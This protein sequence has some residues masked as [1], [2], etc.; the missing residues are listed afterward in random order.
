VTERHG[1]GVLHVI[2][3]VSLQNRFTHVELAR[4][5][6]RGGADTVQFREKRRLPATTLG[7]IAR[8]MLRRVRQHAVRLLINDRVDLAAA[9]GADGVHLGRYDLP[10]AEARRLLG[11]GALIGGTANSLEQAL[12]V[13]RCAVD[14]I[15]VG[16]V[17]GTRS[18][19]NP[20]SRLGLAGLQRIARAVRQPVIAIGGI[21]PDLV[22]AVLEAG[23]SGIAVLSSVVCHDDP[24]EQ[25]SRFRAAISRF[26][27]R[28]SHANGLERAG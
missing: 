16:P 3:D 23:A 17:F 24:A 2:T 13:S 27:E 10:P 15:G 26:E 21:E 19:A 14:Y 20:A 1:P 12:R 11:E 8:G 18:K 4:L 7:G 25:T 9:I 22:H 28:R 5:A 6:A